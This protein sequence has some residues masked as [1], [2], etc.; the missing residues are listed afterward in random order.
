MAGADRQRD[1][2]PRR[3]LRQTLGARGP[4]RKTPRP[5]EE[6]AGRRPSAHRLRPASPLWFTG[7]LRFS[8]VRVSSRELHLEAALIDAEAYDLRLK[9]LMG[10]SEDCSR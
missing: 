7:R 4:C 8:L 6:L 1:T 10:N 3:A 5:A 2:V 9:S